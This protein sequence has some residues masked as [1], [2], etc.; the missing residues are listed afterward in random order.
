MR[1]TLPT[2]LVILLSVIPTMLALPDTVA[3]QEC[4]WSAGAGLSIP[5]TRDLRADGHT[6]KL[7]R[8]WI[9]RLG[10]TC[11]SSHRRFGFDADAQ[12][13]GGIYLFSLMG[14]LGRVFGVGSDLRT[15]RIE[16]AGSAGFAYAFHATD[17][18]EVLIPERREERPGR[19][20]DLPGLGLTVGGSVRV[21]LPTS[22]SASVLLEIGLRASSLP[23]RELDGILDDTPRVVVTFPITFG[24]QLSL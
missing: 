16:V 12:D 11:G 2:S 15:P 4:A 5:T 20:V 8:G 14:R 19:E 7:T 1:R 9:G 23:T 24:Y 18:V 10:H 3:A 6:P 17:Y 13:I 21:G 22:P